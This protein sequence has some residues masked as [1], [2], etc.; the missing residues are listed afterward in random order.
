M[1]AQTWRSHWGLTQDPFDCDDAD[2][3]LFLA[4]LDASG[5]HV[6][7]LSG[8]AGGASGA[9][10]V[11]VDA[12]GNT[13]MTGRCDGQVLISKYDSAG[14]L[15]WSRNGVGPSGNNTGVGVAVDA[16][17]NVFVTG[18][19]NTALD[20]GGEAFVSD[21][22]DMFV[23]KFDLFGSHIWSL[24]AVGSG[25]D[26]GV[27]VAVSPIGNAVATGYFGAAGE[28]LDFGAGPLTAVGLRDTF[29]A[30]FVDPQPTSLLLSGFTAQPHG[31]EIRLSWETSLEN[32]HDGFNVYRGL[33]LDSA[34]RRIN[35]QLVRG[36]SPYSYLDSVVQPST[37]YYY[38]LGVVGLNGDETLSLPTSVVSAPWGVKTAV[39]FASP[40]PF[41]EETQL[42]FALTAPARARLAV[43]DVG[44]R[45]VRSVVDEELR[46]GDHVA[47]WDGRDDGGALV[48]R[49]IYFVK[50][51]AGDDSFT[52]K[53]SFLGGR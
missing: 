31:Q 18:L 24:G 40:S 44:G 23:A 32:S 28:T 30:E 49:G 7:S 34:Y 13:V 4:R 41:R 17:R 27:D 12:D 22:W 20:L 52:R 43:Y 46:E 42:S 36:A 33:Q 2:K 51:T 53:V 38:K 9:L 35:G 14:S 48:G 25:Q 39:V 37:T 45:L 6:W 47:T 19:F 8:C 5:N 21:G 16:S 1:F 26:V 3:D 11:T 29:V 50:L 10:D 15:L